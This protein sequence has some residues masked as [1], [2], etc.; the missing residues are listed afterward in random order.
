MK[1]RD[2]NDLP[3]ATRLRFVQQRFRSPQS[4]FVVGS[5][6]ACLDAANTRTQ[7]ILISAESIE[8]DVSFVKAEHCQLVACASVVYN[9]F[10]TLLC[11]RE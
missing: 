8:H 11:V 2:E 3:R 10:R 4:L 7:L 6:P 9:R 1:I 5:V